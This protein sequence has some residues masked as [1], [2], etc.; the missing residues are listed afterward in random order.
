MENKNYKN[1]KGYKSLP[2]FQQAEIIHDFTAEFVD[3]Y[4]N[5]KSRTKDQMEQAAR[6]GKQNIAEGYLQ[7]SMEGRIKLLGIARGS[8]EEL[9][10]DYQDFLRQKGMKFWEKESPKARA[11]RALAYSNYKN[12]NLY[13]N[14]VDNPEEAANAMICLINQTN[15]LLDQKLRWTEER[16]AQEGGFRENLFKKRRDFLNRSKNLITFIIF[17]IIISF[18]AVF[19]GTKTAHAAT[20]FVSIVDPGG[21]GDYSS[22]SAWNTGVAADLTAATTQVFA[23]TLNNA[24]SDNTTVY[25]CRGESYQ[26]HYATVV[27]ATDTQILADAINGSATETSGDTWESNSACNGTIYFTISNGGDSAIAVAKCQTTDGSA[28]TAAATIDGWTTSDT[29]Y[30]KIWTDPSEPYRHQGKWDETKYRLTISN[31]SGITIEERFV[32]I[33]G[34]QIFIQA[35]NGNTQHGINLDNNAGSSGEII[36]DSSII[37]GNPANTYDYHRGI[38]I[39][40]AGTGTGIKISNNIIYDFKGGNYSAGILAGHDDG[41]SIEAYLYNNTLYNN[42]SGI[43]SYTSGDVTAKNNLVQNCTDGFYGTFDSASTYNI[44]DLSAADGAFGTTADSGTTDSAAANKLIQSG[45][46]FTTTVKVGM[47]IAN[48][49]DTEYTY[50]TAID[51]DT[52][53]SVNDNIME[54]GDNYTIYTNMYGNVAFEDEDNDDFHLDSSDTV[55]KNKGANLYADGSL[56]ITTD[57]DNNARPNSATLFDIGADENITKIYRSVGPSATTAITTGTSNYQAN[58]LTVSGLYATFELPIADNIGVGDAIQYDD[59][60]DGDI[61]AND[62][63]VF[64]DKRLSAQKYRVKTASGGA[65]ASTTAADI[66]WSLFRS[67]TSLENAENADENAGIDSD[68]GSFDAHQRDIANYQEQ[69][70][71]AAYANGSTAD[72]TQVLIDDIT[73][74][75][76]SYIR[77]YTPTSIDEVGASQRHTGVWDDSKYRLEISNATV[78]AI[79]VNKNH[80]RIEGLQVRIVSISSGEPDAIFYY[81]ITGTMDGRVSNNILRGI[82][83]ASVPYPVGACVYNVGGGVFRV[84]DNIIYDFKSTNDTGEGIDVD[85]TD[86]TAYIYNNTIYNTDYGIY[87]WNGTV[88]AKNNLVNGTTDVTNY[89]GSFNSAS[90]NNLSEDTSSPNSGGTDC[91]GHSCRSQAVDF[92]D[93]SGDD[94]HVAPNDTKAKNSGTDLTNDLNLNFNT[95]I[96][97]A[98]IPLSPPFTKGENSSRPYNTTWDIGADEVITPIYRSV[99]PEADG[100]LGAIDD[101]NSQAD[102]LTITTAGAATFEVAVNDI[103]GVGDAL[104]F[105]DDADEDLDASDTILFIHGRTDSTHYTVKTDTGANPAAGTTDNDKWAIYRAYTSL[106][107]AEAGTKNTAIP[108]TFTGGDRDIK[109]N[110][111][112]WNIACYANGTAAD[113]NVSITG[114]TTAPQNYFKVYTPYLTSEVGTSQRHQGKWDATKYRLVD[115]AANDSVVNIV[116]VQYVWIEGLQVHSDTNSGNEGSKITYMTDQV[117]TRIRFSY[118]IIKTTGSGAGVILTP[119]YSNQVTRL[120]FWNNILYGSTGYVVRINEDV[121]YF[122]NNVIYGAGGTSVGFSAEDSGTIIAKNNIVQNVNDGFYTATSGIFSTDSDFNLSNVASDAPSPSYRSGQATTVTFS[123]LTNYDFHLSSADS[124]A[125]DYGADLS[126]DPLY[127]P[128]SLSPHY[129]D[130]DGSTRPLTGS[131]LSWDI[132]ADETATPIYRSVGPSATGLLDWGAGDS[133]TDLS[134][135]GSTATIELAAPDIVGVGDAIQYDSD[136]NANIDAVAFITARASSTSYTVKSAVGGTPVPTTAADQDWRIYRAYLSLSTAE[137]GNE[138]SSIDDTVENFD[139]WVTAGGIDGDDVGRDIWT[140]NEQWNIAAYANGTTADSTAVTISGWTTEPTNYLK[141]YTPTATTEV[142]TT[143]RHPGKWDDSKYKLKVGDYNTILN[144]ENYTWIDGLQVDFDSTLDWRGGINYFSGG[145]ISNS[146]VRQTS[147]AGNCNGISIGDIPTGQLAYVWNNIVYDFDDSSS[148]YYFESID[149]AAIYAY[150]NTAYNSAYGFTILYFDAVLKNNIAQKCTDGYNTAASAYTGSD[151]NISDVSADDAPNATFTGDYVTVKF[152]DEAGKDF[153][154]DPTDI[155]ARNLGADLS[156]DSYL[157]VTTDID[158]KTRPNQGAFDIGADEAAK[159]VYYSV[160]QNV[161]DHGSGGTLTIADGLATFNTAQTAANL[162]VGDKITYDTSSVAYLL[163]KVD[164]THWHLVTATGN[165]PTNEAVAVNVETITHTF[166]SLYDAEN[167]ADDAGYMNATDLAANDFQLNIPCYNDAGAGD[168]TKVTVDGWTTSPNNFI[169]IYTPDDTATE[170]N[171]SQRHNGKYDSSKYRLHVTG[172]A[173][174]G[175]NSLYIIE[176]DW[177][178]IGLQI[179]CNVQDRAADWGDYAFAYYNEVNDGN[180]V[181]FSNNVVILEGAPA[182]AQTNIYGASFTVGNAGSLA[183]PTLKIFNNLFINNQTGNGVD[184]GTGIITGHRQ[185]KAYIYSN[186]F[187]GFSVGIDGDDDST[188][189][190]YLKNNLFY[191]NVAATLGSH[192]N[193]RCNNNATD[194]SDLGYTAGGSDRVS[195]TFSFLDSANDDYHL[196]AADAGARNYGSNLSTDS[197]LSFSTDIDG[198]GRSLWDIGADEGSVEMEASVMQAG[199][200]YSSLSG[201]E[202]GMGTDLVA[203]ATM[204]FSGTRT[205]AI[206]DNAGL[207]LCRSGTYQNIT[208]DTVHSMASQILVE[209][210]SNPSFVMAASDVWYT[211]DTCDSSN[212]F[213]ISTAGGDPAIAVAKIDGAWTSADTSAVEISGWTAGP[214]NYVKIYTTASA[215]HPGKWDETKYRL[216][217]DGYDASFKHNYNGLGYGD[218]G[219]IFVDGLQIDNTRTADGAGAGILIE[220]GINVISNN[221]IRQTGARAQQWSVGI[222]GGAPVS[223]TQFYNNII[224]DFYKGIYWS[225][226]DSNG[227]VSVYNN[228]IYNAG[229]GGIELVE[230]GGTVVY[231]LKNNLVQDSGTTDYSITNGNTTNYADNLSSDATAP[232]GDAIQGA[233]V[234]FVNENK[235]DFHLAQE[236]TSAKNAGT[237]LASDTYISIT[238]DI[239]GSTR[240]TGSNVV[241]IGADEAS[242]MIYYSVGQNTNSNETGAGNVDVDAT[243]RT[244]TF[245]VAQ[246][247]TNMG[248]GDVIDY[249]ADNK[250]CYITEKVSTSIWKCQS[251]TG[252]APTDSGGDVVVNSVHHTFQYLVNAE[253]DSDDAGYLNNSN[254]VTGNYVLNIP[255][256]YD[257]GADE[258]AVRIDDYTTGHANYIKIYTPN[259]TTK[260]VNQTQRH[261]GKWDDGKYN[262]TTT[263][264]VG[265]IKIGSGATQTQHVR[266]DGLQIYRHA[267]TSYRGCISNSINS[268]TGIDLRI[269]NNILRGNGA[270]S[271]TAG[272]DENDVSVNGTGNIHLWNNLI[273]DHNNASNWGIGIYVGGTYLV[274]AYNNTIVGCREGIDTT[275]GANT[276][277]AKN[278]IVKGSGDTNAYVGDFATGTDYN[279]TDGTDTI[280]E[281]SNNRISQTFSFVDETGDDFHLAFADTGAKGYGV[282]L[283]DDVYLAFQNDIDGQERTGNWTISADEPRESEIQ[284]ATQKVE[285]IT[286]GLVLYQSFDGPHM[287]WSNTSAEARDQS[288]SE[289]HGDVDGATTAMGKRGQALYFDGSDDKIT[290]AETNVGTVHSASVWLDWQDSGDGVIVGRYGTWPTYSGYL[291]YIDQTTIYYGAEAGNNVSVAHG[292][293]TSGEW[294]NLAVVRNGTSVKFYKNGAQLGAEQTLGANTAVSDLVSIGS[295]GD[296]TFP[297]KMRLDEIR[298]YNRVLSVDEIGDLYNLGQV[299]MNMSLTNKN[300]DGLVGMWSFDGADMEWADATGE[301]LDRS[302]NVNDGDVVGA[303]AAI[304]KKGQALSF[305]GTSD[306]MSVYPAPVNFPTTES[307]TASLW[308]KPLTTWTSSPGVYKRLVNTMGSPWYEGNINLLYNGDGGGYLRCYFHNTIG[309]WPN[310][311]PSQTV[312]TANNWYH[313]VCI[314]D[315]TADTLTT[316]I[317][318]S[319]DGQGTSVGTPSDYGGEFLIGAGDGCNAEYADSVIDEVRIYDRALTSTEVGDLYRLGQVKLKR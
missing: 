75:A 198:N 233:N 248:V 282:N 88:Y 118:N 268:G 56:A 140:N 95:D 100:N 287:D 67:Y 11:C 1:Y 180:T 256:Y 271:D 247:A 179:I 6:S 296:G 178:V 183:P 306:C 41:G 17:I 278:N 40:N 38:S 125:K 291:F 262:L 313:T 9:L 150:N 113:T 24:V 165:L 301:A 297:A 79:R 60:N 317:N 96:D 89:A 199:G 53:L 86:V 147:S 23:G 109:A 211:A 237:D 66:D 156:A 144:Y 149:S 280:G 51:S 32:R 187:T 162:G 229:A 290:I 305:N 90:S 230:Y 170:A 3:R 205:N 207:Y 58:H 127:P 201:W 272:F 252:G 274:Y 102:T 94:F 78:D 52:Q 265:N 19:T 70:N 5:P 216:V 232:G 105:D 148:A 293:L 234:V 30:I 283:K 294:V 141:I 35:T 202:T 77:F 239:D 153:H 258:T 68:L 97:D 12:Y 117:D 196:A 26:S 121:A 129:T 172:G 133:G 107:L 37:R 81:A 217:S 114:W 62:S 204:V 195:Q 225:F 310:A 39:W 8:L 33:Y 303:T 188:K 106:S 206:A 124:Y 309:G 319:E 241:D 14:Y 181:E 167:E 263:D 169:K 224:Y 249:D 279:A 171:T 139:D 295:Y 99:A 63:I 15:Q 157:P 72:T 226:G 244:A 152:T 61:D 112:Q 240:P 36:V 34:V 137:Q 251:V 128:S 184:T 260:E 31:D 210:V 228:T 122:Y 98:E 189:L 4:I 85:D 298:I 18:I 311:I 253:D 269:S 138:S 131:G 110:S 245:T 315:S 276:M 64:I 43:Y 168:T 192:V 166:D 71:F 292:G 54:S 288:G 25:L 259:D 44:T 164:T 238:T 173:G 270:S 151:Y 307:Y 50:V 236:D 45:Q 55:A 80:V 275:W 231:N 203:P 7:K 300:T 57:I 123:D 154:L 227:D 255:C 221:V 174:A 101:D 208:A 219:K 84:W 104:V 284:S 286:D 47:I 289:N 177:K 222:G 186:T 316:Y 142:G 273:Y 223:G 92:V 49:S 261:S 254:L 16:F 267:D 264:V 91:G 46:N 93:E 213:T 28:D 130:I 243:T 87:A 48:T 42:D 159:G 83:N 193:T 304:G 285:S 20:E 185:H 215:R 59:D 135:S 218:N 108:I 10:N 190:H 103:V 82:T 281:G 299:K 277:I 161:T 74:S 214:N 13:K 29:N 314:Y 65:P 163:R 143:Q 176:N 312:F 132:G 246:T 318:G 73:T 136:N 175:S 200:D 120:E 111:E 158:G 302:G 220:G 155:A 146:I 212:Y 308:F 235:K 145:K 191:D 69:W 209:N 119:N 266:I 21:A 182:V 76:D 197:V 242:T 160:G 22:L 194:L 27:H 126:Q 134:I 2:F 257:T 115:S 116:T 250:I